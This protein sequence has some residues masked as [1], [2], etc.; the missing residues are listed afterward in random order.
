MTLIGRLILLALMLSALLP[1]CIADERCVQ[2]SDPQT[3]TLH[4]GDSY[5]R[6][7]YE[8][9]CVNLPRLDER[10]KVS[11]KFV[12]LELYTNGTLVRSIVLR[13]G[14]SY[15]YE[16]EL[17]ITAESIHAPNKTFET[18][19][20]DP[21]AIIRTEVRGRPAITITTST[22]RH[23]YTPP[24]GPAPE[25]K[26]RIEL[27]LKVKNDGS[28]DLYECRIKVD[29]GE[30][31]LL[32]GRTCIHV[33]ELPKDGE[34]SHTLV[35]E[36]PYPKTMKESLI[37]RYFAINVSVEGKDIKGER[38]SASTTRT[39]EVLPMWSTQDIRFMKRCYPTW[40]RVNETV[41][42]KLYIENDGIYA[43]HDV[44]IV[45]TPPA[46]LEMLDPSENLSWNV[47]I[48]PG[49]RAEFS[50][51]LRVVYGSW[52]AG[53]ESSSKISIT[54]PPATASFVLCGTSYSITS[55]EPSLSVYAPNVSVV[56]SVNTTEPLVGENVLVSVST[57]VLWDMRA[58]V[59]VMDSIPDGAV[60]VSG[61][62]TD[63]AIMQR[64]EIRTLTYVI[65]FEKPGTYT[66][67]PAYVSFENLQ[68]YRATVFSS[69]VEVSVRE[70][71]VEEQDTPH[72]QDT[73]SERHDAPETNDTSLPGFGALIS[74]CSVLATL[75]L[76]RRG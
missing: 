5:S 42:V 27:T 20:Y 39:I 49:E 35:F 28:A 23:S 21:Y 52:L 65:R 44:R 22:D 62:L 34:V 24:R 53:D 63:H 17:R 74:M 46:G 36:L 18:D 8:I 32:T 9:V 59:D 51:R 76:R 55:D 38:Y 33:G 67:P 48:A 25:Q 72:E 54:L 58:K 41:G 6:G 64:N 10:G 16:D 12:G 26:K 19:V 50:Y 66:L 45:D 4:W 73:P 14:E 43:L 15:E 70:P 47:S 31:K 71:G 1:I 30:L 68:N 40:A 29:I 37:T 7:A 75:F 13:E 69:P 57:K 3:A 56:K 2:W 11:G 60:L 61:N